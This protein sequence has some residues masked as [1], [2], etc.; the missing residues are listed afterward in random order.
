[1]KQID[2][3]TTELLINIITFIAGWLTKLLTSKKVKQ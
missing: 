3:S 1:M 2:P